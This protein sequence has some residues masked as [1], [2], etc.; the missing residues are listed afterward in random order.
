[1]ALIDDEGD[2][3]G[4]VN[5]VDA[6]V[7]LLVA[8]VVV[9]GAAFVLADDPDPKPETDTTHVTLDLGTQPAYVVDAINEGDVYEPTDETRL[10]ITDVHLTPQGGNVAVLARVEIQGTLDNDG[11]LVY[12]NAPPRLGR[13]LQ[14]V[15]DRYQVDGQIRAVG[16]GDA[17]DDEE[18]T[19]LLRG[20]LPAS[21]AESVAPGDELRLAGRTVATVE[22]AAVY[23]TADPETRRVLLAVSLDAHRQADE[24]R[25]AG[26]PLRRGQTLTLPTPAYTFDGTID[27]VGG[28]PELDAATTR[29]VTLRMENVHEDMADV[30]APGMTEYAG[31]E[32]VAEV[33]AVETE[34]SI[35]IATGDDGTVNVADHPVDRQVTLTADLRVRETTTGIRFKGN[36]LRQGS[37]VVLDLGT[38]TIEA[39]VVSVTA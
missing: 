27:R 36:P 20:S 4:V 19:V 9:A 37:T 22:D 2:L 24:L 35:I 33:T 12:E 23:A 14:I 30:I 21:A 6:L 39:T 18:T 26:T 16:E 8:A 38:V 7:V 11:G 28:D 15:T 1:M 13:T 31:D 5:V 29:E 17:I 32:T 10:T 25:F 34:P 3:F